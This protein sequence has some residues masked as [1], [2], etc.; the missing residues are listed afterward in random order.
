M[1]NLV[2]ETIPEKD[3]VELAALMLQKKDCCREKHFAVPVLQEMQKSGGPA[4]ILPGTEFHADLAASFRMKTSTVELELNFARASSQ[5]GAMRKRCHGAA[6]MSAKHVG[7]EIKLAQRRQL[8]SREWQKQQA[9]IAKPSAPATY[10]GLTYFMKNMYSD[11]TSLDTIKTG[12]HWF[13]KRQDI[14]QEVLA[15]WRCSSQVTKDMWSQRAKSFNLCARRKHMEQQREYDSQDIC[16]ADFTKNLATKQIDL[17][18]TSL[19]TSILCPVDNVDSAAPSIVCPHAVVAY[20][21][22]RKMDPLPA[23]GDATRQNADVT[24]ERLQVSK[25]LEQKT[26]KESG[27]FNRTTEAVQLLSQCGHGLHGL[28]DDEFGVSKV[29]IDHLV[30]NVPGFVQRSHK[31]LVMNHGSVCDKISA[32]FED[33]LSEE[34]DIEVPR[35]CEHLLGR[36]CV[37]DIKDAKLFANCLE[38]VKSIARAMAKMRSVKIGKLKYL[39]P[40]PNTFFPILLLMTSDQSVCHARLVCRVTFKPLECDFVRCGVK[41]VQDEFHLE[42]GCDEFPGTHKMHL[43]IEHANEFAVW[44]SLNYDPSWQCRLFY[45]YDIITS[46]FTLIL[47][48]AHKFDT[49]DKIGNNSFAKDDC[50]ALAGTHQE[51]S[52]SSAIC[53]AKELLKVLSIDAGMRE[54]TRK[55]PSNKP[56]KNSAVK[57]ALKSVMPTACFLTNNLIKMLLC[58]F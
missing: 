10:N 45:E 36:Y 12:S 43:Q 8:A 52:E 17:V 35:S 37:A 40:T 18:N 48:R 25:Q 11:R 20:A 32:D 30:D 27:Q 33:E 50:L 44:F 16:R 19:K 38:M 9:A 15:A 42:P 7:S 58:V 21:N 56:Q 57:K 5:R 49:A 6:A 34:D 14:F 2:D 54:K 47:K 46:P 51:A 39:S 24:L 53:K 31:Q 4:A 41:R 1:A 55:Q 26:L 28:G 22:E 3:R 13:E 23:C 29:I